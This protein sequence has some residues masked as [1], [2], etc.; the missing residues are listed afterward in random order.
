MPHT[1]PHP[2]NSHLLNAP[3]PHYSHLFNAHAHESQTLM[4][5]SLR[6]VKMLASESIS[7]RLD[8]ITVS[9]TVN[10]ILTAFEQ[11][12][13]KHDVHTRLQLG[14]RAATSSRSMRSQLTEDELNTYSGSHFVSG[15]FSHGA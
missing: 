9:T 12:L 4:P 14:V 11:Q 5:I 13:R 3:H 6:L 10:D 7:V 15:Q 8:D 2:H 1:L